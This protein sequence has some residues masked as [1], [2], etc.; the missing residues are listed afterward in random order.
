MKVRCVVVYQQTPNNYCA[1]VPDFPGCVSTG[2]DVGGH[3]AQ[4]P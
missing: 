1:Y 4:H 3:P 2:E